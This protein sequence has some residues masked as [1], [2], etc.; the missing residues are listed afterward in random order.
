MSHPLVQL[1]F[2]ISAVA[3]AAGLVSAVLAAAVGL[4]LMT[5]LPY[6][7]AAATIQVCGKADVVP[8]GDQGSGLPVQVSRM[9]E[10]ATDWSVTAAGA[11]A[12]SFHS[13]PKADGAP[14]GAEMAIWP[15]GRGK[16]QPGGLM[17]ASAIPLS[18]ASWDVWFERAEGR[19]RIGYERVGD[20]SAVGG[21]DV[22]AFTKDALGR[23][24]VRP[25]WYL[26]GVEADFHQRVCGFEVSVGPQ[27]ACTARFAVDE[28]WSTGFTATVVVT[29]SGGLPVEGWAV[30]WTFPADQR[31]RNS[32]DSVLVQSGKAVRA[33]NAAYN[34]KIDVAGTAEFGFVGDGQAPTGVQFSCV[35]W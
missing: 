1:A 20:G 31:V 9:A 3:A 7:S 15:D 8:A 19:N 29:N 4:V 5:V 6:T 23:G 28:A 14:D 30:D 11:Y 22:H 27:A 10:V 18:G 13:K 24:W 34:A 25:E 21:L 33:V 26:I 16:A 12:V 2:R 35:S 17:V 32:W